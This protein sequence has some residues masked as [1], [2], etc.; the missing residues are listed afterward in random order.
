M[1]QMII[2]TALQGSLRVLTL[3]STDTVETARIRHQTWPTA[4]AVL[5]RALSG[6]LLMA[7]NLKEEQKLTLRFLG[8]GPVG[9][10]IV[11]C[12]DRG[13]VRG[14]V[15]EPEVH[16]PVTP[17]GKLDVGAAVGQ[18]TLVVSKDLGFGEPYVGQVPIQNG[19]IASDIAYYYA[20]S[21]QTPTALGLGVLV[22]T[23][24][25][26]QAA[27]G[28][29]IQLMP[30]ASDEVLD[31]LE[32]RLFNLKSPTEILRENPSA[33]Y[34]LNRIFSENEYEIL[35]KRNISFKCTCNTQRLKDLL[36]SLDS[37]EL[38]EMIAQEE[39][40]EMICHFC[41]QRYEF[42]KEELRQI[43]S[44]KASL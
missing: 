19:E 30:G 16:L 8:D 39:N 36:G 35:E 33:E 42:T 10:V 6:G 28:Y 37:A 24:N 32:E 38:E 13:E 7:A 21:E 20:V 3:L 5:G 27:G 25:E 14:Y 26:V 44:E 1:D 15:Q 22:G 4:T 41:R 17:Y 29:F 43:L 2:A 23:Q 11:D 9:A 31:S 34:L 18:G 40:T 12:N